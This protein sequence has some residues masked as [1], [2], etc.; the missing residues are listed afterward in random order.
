MRTLS[1]AP[2]PCCA[3]SREHIGGGLRTEHVVDPPVKGRR[4]HTRLDAAAVILRECARPKWHGAKGALASAGAEVNDARTAGE[5]RGAATEERATGLK[6]RRARM[7][8]RAAEVA[9]RGEVVG[10]GGDQ[11]G[12]GAG[13]HGNACTRRRRGRGCHEPATR[14]EEEARGGSAA[15]RKGC[16]REQGARWMGAG[17]RGRRA[18]LPQDGGRTA[19]EQRLA[20]QEERPGRRG[21]A[22]GGERRG[23]GRRRR[24]AGRR[25]RGA[26]RR[27][28]GAGR[29]RGGAALCPEVQHPRSKCSTVR[30]QSAALTTPPA[31]R[32]TGRA[33]PAAVAP[34]EQRRVGAAGRGW[35]ADASGRASVPSPAG[36]TRDRSAAAL[37]ARRARDE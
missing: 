13:G 21:G 3:A 17:R 30:K 12:E 36:G 16:R 1:S 15:A 35:P 9:R 34:A 32:R 37:P 22:Q 27:R 5:T 8:R 20:A 26:G 19:L 23:A 33:G 28:R 31:A 11:A 25:R 10:G 7:T 14:P 24:G 6:R 4:I 18:G 29:R 2:S